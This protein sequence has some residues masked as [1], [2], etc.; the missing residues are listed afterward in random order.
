M[1]MADDIR[2]EQSGKMFAVGLYPDNVLVLNLPRSTPAP[3][4]KKPI[5]LDGLSLSF[6]FLGSAGHHDVSISIG[7]GAAK[8]LSVNVPEGGHANIILALRP[9]LIREFG[10]K[11][12]LVLYGGAKHDFEFEV[13]RRDVE[14]APGRLAAIDA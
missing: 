9:L 2:A 11:P 4:A 6:T 13:R 8:V 7:D 3:S 5:A 14:S 10:V 1:L 12:V